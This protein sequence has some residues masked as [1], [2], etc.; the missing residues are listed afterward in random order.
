[1]SLYLGWLWLLYWLSV[2][3]D[4]SKAVYRDVESDLGITRR[5]PFTNAA[6]SQWET[7][8]ARLVLTSWNTVWEVQE[9]SLVIMKVHALITKPCI[10]VLFSL[11]WPKSGQQSLAQ[12]KVKLLACCLQTSVHYT[13]TVG[14]I[15]QTLYLEAG[16]RKS[17]MTESDVLFPH[18]Q[19]LQTIR[20]GLHIYKRLKSV[21]KSLCFAWVQ[22]WVHISN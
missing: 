4:E 8:C 1:M 11:Y 15:T 12:Q 18:I 9:D 10:F 21:F 2:K 7:V 6:R 13:L 14:S 20:T 16:Q 22:N 17:P 3:T 19:L 5:C